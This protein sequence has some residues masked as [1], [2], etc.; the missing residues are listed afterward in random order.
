MGAQK[1]LLSIISGEEAELQMDELTE[2]IEYIQQKAGDEAE[3]IFGHGIDPDLGESIRVTIIATGFENDDFRT[4]KPEKKKVIDL[5]SNRQIRLFEDELPEKKEERK[6][7]QFR[8]SKGFSSP[9]QPDKQDEESRIDLFQNLKD[10]FEIREV[11][12]QASN[13]TTELT[14]EENELIQKKRML[15]EKA[16]ERSEKMA[17]LKNQMMDTDEFKEK[18]EVPAYLR[19][20]VVLKDVPHSSEQNISRYNLN[21]DNQILGNNRFLHDNVD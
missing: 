13:G 20:K 10:D 19:K 5:E 1:I 15:L 14:P 4:I 18:V 16:R 8:Y 3:V 17:G 9:H 2:I 6:K 7:E 21:D 11:E 12:T